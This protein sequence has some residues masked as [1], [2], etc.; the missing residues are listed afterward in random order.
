MMEAI[1]GIFVLI[2]GL[3]IAFMV[4]QALGFGTLFITI[5]ILA[6]VLAIV[7]LI[8]GSSD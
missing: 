8:L 6:I 3:F 4:Y 5:V 2:V 7:F 1:V